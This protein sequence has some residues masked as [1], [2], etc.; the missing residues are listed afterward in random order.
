MFY[1]CA[2]KPR[3][4]RLSE[5][6]RK[7]ALDSLNGKYGDDTMRN[8]SAS[9]DTIPNFDN[10]SEL[11]KYDAAI[12]K[13]C[14][15]S[16][17]R[18]C[19]N[20]KIS[21]AATYGAAILHTVPLTR[22]DE[23][24][25]SSISHLTAGFDKVLKIGIDGIEK[26][27]DG[28]TP[29]RMSL[30][31]TICSFRIWH[32]RYLD[33]T[34][35][36]IHKNLTR[37][38]FLP[39]LNFYEAVQSLWF[40]FAFTRLCGNWSGI[41]RIDEMLGPFLQKDLQ[42]KALTLDEAREILAH[43]F[44]KGCEWIQSK[45]IADSGDAQHYQNIVLGGIDENGAEITN[46]VTYLVLDIVE[47]LGISD[48][49]ITVRIN[50]NSPDKLLSRA[51]EVI[52]HGGGVIAFYYEDLILDSLYKFGYDKKE[53]KN[54]ANDGCW[55]IQIPGKTYFCYVP[56][57]ALEILLDNTLGLK[58]QKPNIFTSY[59]ELYEKFKQDL[60]KRIEI[61][62]EEAIA[63]RNLPKDPCPVISLFTEN[64]AQSNRSYLEG[65]AKYTV[66]SPH[67]G[68]APDAGNSLYAI[69]KLVFDDKKIDFESLMHTLKNNWEG[70]EFLR[71]YAMNKYSY[72]GNDNDESDSFT[73]S[74]INDFADMVANLNG[75][76]Y[77]MFPAGVSTFGR[78]IDWASTRCAAPFGSKKGDIL[79]GNASPLSGTDFSG[80]TAAI[81]SY[82]KIN[83]VKQ[84]S[85]AALDIK[86]HSSATGGKN[87]VNALI[88]LI[89]GFVK[90]NG[91]FMQ[92]DIADSEILKSAQ[93]RPDEYK[94]LSV[95]VSGW[96][97]RFVTLSSEW[98]KMI[99]GRDS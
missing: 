92:V 4:V 45:P 28:D 18:I 47:E 73:V 55:E 91:F 56:I 33:S 74:V 94:T 40:V 2:D 58:N 14:E 75:R 39:P 68:G 9:S 46:A 11:E 82:C 83:L 85:G 49:P 93:E 5:K 78:Q 20:E 96:N 22:N 15:T 26:E 6:T 17:I 95:R 23:R 12:K 98:Q 86:L 42:N 69:K 29:F 13:I 37:V 67:I 54:F 3:P 97:A 89:K 41:G 71:Q 61:L 8:F 90:L 80:A 52:R 84:S 63:D 79:S 30:K 25:W 60:N 50:K 70:S 62:Y 19:E 36:I 32:K 24:I 53:A 21:G 38:P 65:G 59:G 16:P 1:T 81:K 7:F 31:N 43:F 51:A 34:K 66:I 99:I 64:C 76:C 44:I 77:I 57:D 10:L 27:F 72:Y 87:G 88:S 35:E 48:F